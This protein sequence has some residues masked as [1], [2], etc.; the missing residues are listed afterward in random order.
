LKFKYF[1]SLFSYFIACGTVDLIFSNPTERIQGR[2]RERNT[3][4][5]LGKLISFILKYISILQRQK[6]AGQGCLIDKIITVDFFGGI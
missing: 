1:L 2:S 3:R 6:S 5:I 4:K